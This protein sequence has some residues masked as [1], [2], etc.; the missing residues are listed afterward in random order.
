MTGPNKVE[1]ALS[2]DKREGESNLKA[3]SRAFD[4]LLRSLGKGDD[5]IKAF[6]RLAA[7][8]ESGKVAI[9]SLDAQ[10][11]KLLQVF[12]EGSQLAAD[13]DFLGLSAHKDIQ[14]EIFR[15]RD[16][17]DRL[18][19]SGKLTGA[20]LAQAALKTEERI[21]ELHHETNGWTDSL[22][23]AKAALAGVAASAAGVT[24]VAVAAIKFETSMANVAKVVN[25]TDAQI[26]AL[27]A[28]LRELATELPMEGG[29][30]GLAAIAAAGGQLGVPIE[31]LE[32]FVTLA[33]KM[34]VAF[35]LSADQ[36]AKAV[37]E[38]A[39]VFTLPLARV[40]ELG[41]AINTLG[42]TMS[43]READIVDV[44]TRIGGSATQFNLTA[45]QSAA[46]AAAM[47]SL[48]MSSEVAGTGINAMLAKLQTAKLQGADFQA[49]L[50][51][52][53]I[54]A[55][56]LAKDIRANPQAALLEFLRTLKSLDGQS[57]AEVITRLFGLEYQDKISR[58][59]AGLGQYEAALGRVGSSSAIAGAMEREYQKRLETTEAQ[60]QLLKQGVEVV[61]VNL[62]TVLLPALRSIVTILGDAAA[63][64]AKFVET[65]PHL[66]TLAGA[67][68][69]AVVSA[70]SLRLVLLALTVAGTR[71]FAA[72]FGSLKDLNSELGTAIT[73][74]GKLQTA[75]SLAAAA[76]IGWEIG[77][78]AK[79][80]FK[81][82]ELAGIALAGG[83]T[84]LAER[85][86]YAWFVFENQWSPRAIVE[87]YDRLQQRLK[88]IDATYAEMFAEAQSRP[89]KT[90]A[91]PAPPP[92]APAPAASTEQPASDAQKLAGS[93]AK[94]REAANEL[95]VDLAQFATTVSPEFEV[96]Q[97]HLD[98]LIAALPKLKDSGVQTG[99]ALK[100]AL[101]KM[102]DGARNPAELL[103]LTERVRE[104]GAA[105]ELSRPQLA[106]LFDVVRAKAKE[107]TAEA[108]QLRGEIANLLA[109]AASVRNGT[110]GAGAK[111]EDRRSRG[112]SDADREALNW[113]NAD[114]AAT[115]AQRNATFAQNAAIDGRAQQ[116]Q[117]Y[118]ARAAQ[119]IQQASSYADKLKDDT[120]AA[121]MF[122]RIAE[123]EAR[124]IEA[125]AAVKQRQLQD[126]E[127]AS[128][129][130]AQQLSQLETRLQ[131][132]RDAVT[133]VKVDAS[134]D[135]ATAALDQ[136]KTAL[137]ALP[138]LKTI[139]VEVV[140]KQ[141]IQWSNSSS[142]NVG[143]SLADALPAR[144]YGGRLPGV[145]HGDRSDNVLYWGTPGEHV[146][147]IPAVRYYGRAF[148]DGINN[149]RIP[150]HG[151]GGEIAGAAAPGLAQA[152]GPGDMVGAN[153]VVPGV[154]SF[155]V[156]TTADVHG[157]MSRAFRI[158]ALKAG[159]R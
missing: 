123:A 86:K 21:R 25:G 152:T 130:Q 95:G 65:F 154:G 78:W 2:V 155:P 23:N 58:L 34:S 39:N 30:N 119:L 100:A 16:A 14:E 112:L 37:A 127:A 61:A 98:T 45:E 76:M 55:N 42:N 47:L 145:A 132:L 51:E 50:A 118:A 20:E 99:A 36:S 59:V 133:T 108:T 71:G 90:A 121:N 3:F 29:V 28:R 11:R 82:V 67:L 113:R 57:R 111:A 149:M 107:A 17:Y 84:K 114:A 15:T 87:E 129:S 143:E 158:A 1:I 88:E 139:T 148:I 106:S 96:L 63:G 89:A 116:A 151:F 81:E 72:V 125:Q 46:L 156:K 124:A 56:K 44:L 26:A 85:A 79:T 93:L 136:V 4:Q 104:L 101:S 66:A 49:A 43:A 12:K 54:S 115:E 19:A 38:L 7:D 53:G 153:L 6:R 120:D 144:A 159:G 140:T 105:G 35:N 110:A 68:A 40:G 32:T 92:A 62:G 94:A 97:A 137:A 122:D 147:Q 131:Q 60:L 52:M 102:I 91:P 18:A 74:V 142:G 33:A 13:R 73:K 117:Q 41:D 48:G 103:A 27:S 9:A 157:A 77:T 69:T 83:L 5:D 70:G 135:P 141:D 126:I 128:A 134:V 8:V 75:F 31:Q 138:D 64:V 22:V 10:T 109:E 146:I 80:E 24:A 150:R